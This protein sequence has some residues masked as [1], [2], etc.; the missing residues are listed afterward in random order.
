MGRRWAAVEVVLP[1]LFQN[2]DSSVSLLQVTVKPVQMLLAKFC[3]QLHPRNLPEVSNCLFCNH[4][5]MQ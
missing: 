5:L 3:S 1:L 2:G 4:R